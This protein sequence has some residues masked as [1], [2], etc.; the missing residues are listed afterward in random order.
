MRLNPRS[1]PPLLVV[2]LL[3]AA[4][5]SL[6]WL[7]SPTRS[8]TAS[9]A[10]VVEITYMGPGGPI[11]GALDDA[12]RA[13]EEESRHA[14]ASDPSRPIYR[15]I[16]GQ[17]ASR[18]MTGDP[19]R[20]LLS[21]AGG[22]P[23]DVIYFD[24][25]AV[26]E[27]SARGA[28]I[29]VN[30]FIARDLVAGHAD[31]IRRED[32]YP[33]TWNEVVFTHPATGKGGLY[34]IPDGF[35]SRALIYNKD[36]LRR[37]G[38]VD[39]KGEARPP[40]TWEELA[41]MS[42]ALTEHDENGRITR[43][44]FAPLSGAGIF[45][46]YGWQNGGEILSV[47]GRTV[48]LDEPRFVEALDWMAKF[49]ERLGGIKNVLAFDS[50]MQRGDLDPFV[51]N[52]MA[53]KF[54]GFWAL[55]FG[56]SQYGDRVNYGVAPPPMP[57]RELAAGRSPESWV[58]GWCY[59]IPATAHHPKAAWELI[60]FLASPRARR[61]MAE[62]QRLAAESQGRLFIPSQSAHRPVNEE[63]MTRY[64]DANP[65]IPENLRVGV[66]AFNDI[67]VN[68]R[69]RPA[70]PVGQV[71]FNEATT[72]GEAACYG[73][74]SA[75]AA[76][77]RATANSQRA[78]DRALAPARGAPVNWSHLVWVYGLLVIVG[79]TVLYKWDTS[80]G[81]RSTMG[82]ALATVRL[83]RSDDKGGVLEGAGGGMFRRQ[84]LGGFLCASPWII[85]FLIFTGG[86]ILFSIVVSFA[87]YDILRPATWTGLANYSRMF[88]GDDLFLVAVQNTLYMMIGIPLGLAASLG[89]ALLL[90]VE[91]RGVA[92]WRTCFYLPSIVPAVASSIL[93]I[94]IFNPQAGLLN[95]VLAAFGIHGPNWLQDADTSKSALILMGLWG[96]GGGMIIWIAGLKGIPES[97]YEAARIDGATTWNQFVNITLPMLSPYIFFNTIMGVIGTLQVFSQA[98]IMTQGG[99]VNSTLFYA[100]HLFNHA[101]RY[102]NMGYASALAWVLVLVVLVLTVIQ[103]KLSKRWVHYEGD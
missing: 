26:A 13:F 101:F 92:L 76:L 96:A 40:K 21:V 100:Y 17:N 4:G 38:Y 59:A 94:W 61:I 83:G 51:T 33:A 95:D 25:F 35:E 99:P 47:D 87:D 82:R 12:V 89:I 34:G 84:W 7:L 66:H 72:A 28:F 93:W 43:L 37:A 11:S 1:L 31:A 68:S 53:M 18:G 27:W 70:S 54:E 91:I 19:T 88:T 80:A 23:P 71:M 67:V 45:Y 41:D 57:A 22:M 36:W 55:R 50:V 10:G 32:Y 42:A 74:L 24:R 75:Q 56:L 5:L 46:Q 60:R 81:I 30:P 3:S 65:A 78:L 58:G 77:D 73:V 29:D 63:N 86:P 90:N 79:A 6:L 20:F 14:H 52:R 85:G 39:E 8:A 97:Y 64:V 102:L 49:Y 103:M 48:T 98:F 15:V 62:S 44:G 69:F 2:A 9:P 16:S